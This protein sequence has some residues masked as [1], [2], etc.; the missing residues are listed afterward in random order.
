MFTLS[1]LNC[2]TVDWSL[3]TQIKQWERNVV[4]GWAGV[5]GEGW[6]TSSPKNA[7]VGGK[8]TT[9]PTLSP[10]TGAYLPK[11][12]IRINMPFKSE[13]LRYYSQKMMQNKLKMEFA[14][15]NLKRVVAWDGQR[16]INLGCRY[17]HASPFWLVEGNCHDSRRRGG[18]GASLSS[19]ELFN[20]FLI[21]GNNTFNF[22]RI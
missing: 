18:I 17:P 8:L 1:T 14:W 12:H 2:T 4:F 15:P 7:C 6:K 16:R 9:W 21:Y 11:S 13:V 3:T 20:P 22:N 19:L 10:R 5:G